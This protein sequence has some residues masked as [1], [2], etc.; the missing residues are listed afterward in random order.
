MGTERRFWSP[1][2]VLLC[3]STRLAFPGMVQASP[4]ALLI[5]ISDYPGTR[6]PRL[7][8]PKNDIPLVRTLLV[9]RL[10]VPE[11]NIT[12]LLDARATHTGIQKAFAS[13][14]ERVQP[15]DLVYIHFS[16]H[17][18]YTDDLN[19]DE[20]LGKQDQTWVPYGASA[21]KLPGIDDY[22]ILDDQLHEWLIPLYQKTPHV[23][24]VAD[25]CHSATVS[26]GVVTGV[27]AAPVDQRPHPLGKQ[28]FKS[29]PDPPG[30]RIGAARDVESAIETQIGGKSY[31]VFSWYWVEALNLVKPGET[32][33]DVFRRVDT[34]VTTVPG[35]SQRPQMEGHGEV[36]VLGGQVAG[37]KATVPVSAVDAKSRGVQIG[38]GL[39]SGVTAGS[40]YRLATATEPPK[41]DQLPAIEITRAE[42]FTG[43]AKLLRGELKVGDLL[44]ETE[45]AYPF[46]PI[47]L[48]V[49]GDFAER[50]DKALIQ[51]LSRMI[52]ELK[53]FQPAK[54][55]ADA[56]W[57]L[58]VLRPERNGTEYVYASEAQTLPKSAPQQ[59]PEVW[60]ISPQE[61]LLHERMRIPLKSADTG[62]AALQENLAK[63]AR[64]QQLKQLASN[65]GLNLTVKAVLLWS[66]P[67]C[68]DCLKLNGPDGR[69]QPYR[70]QGNVSLDSLTDRPPQLGNVISFTVKNNDP[71]R[72][73]YLYFLDLTPEGGITAIFP[74]PQMIQEQARIE[75]GQERDLSRETGLLLN[76]PGTEL[77]KLIATRE[78][79]DVRLFE[80]ADYRQVRGGSLNPLERLLSEAMYTRG[81]AVS[82]SQDDWGT[83][84]VEFEVK[85]K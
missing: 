56:D 83:M 71:T 26:R 41:D 35:V 17:G 68:I 12:P 9:S 75:P 55:R 49:E 74:T 11:Q 64:V 8:G 57:I 20:E 30:V 61:K 13:L 5:G 1:L 19:G 73:Y 22:D 38:A 78:P 33:D 72:A 79:I 32:W 24:F 70:K 82:L 25:S 85:G 62:I 51:R 50:R 81:Q 28:E 15:G 36:T 53:G 14:A 67:T 63:F 84:Q 76:A 48:R 7:Q 60:V 58:Y 27:R 54:D 66:D 77:V 18:S 34:L 2:A 6:F 23:V 52:G 42:P 39:V 44:V 59:P 40:R 21:G 46:Q 65:G 16:G 4:H 3:W 47:R 80:S 69:P 37:L 10:G 43:E 29:M 45:H 31:G